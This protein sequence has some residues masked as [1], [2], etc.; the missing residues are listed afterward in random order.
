MKFKPEI[1][2]QALSIALALVGS[3]AVTGLITTSEA[4]SSTS[5]V[6]TINVVAYWDS[7]CTKVVSSVDWGIPEPGDSITKTLYIKNTVNAPLTVNIYC[8]E[9]NPAAAESY[10]TFTWDGQGAE[11]NSDEVLEA[12]LTLAISDLITEITDFSFN[13]VIEGTI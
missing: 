13:I 6:R 9:W 10:L 7:R 8:S 12:E 5:S 1:G 4:L 2:M 11:I 3:L